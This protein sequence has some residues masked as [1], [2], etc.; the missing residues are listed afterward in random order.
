MA[1]TQ[2]VLIARVLST[3]DDDSYEDEDILLIINRGITEIAG[4]A[5]RQHGN[6]LLAPLPDLFDIDTVTL[7]GDATSVILPATFQ[8]GLIKV[9]DSKGSTLRKYKSF[10]KFSNRYPLLDQAGPPESYAQK[11][12]TIYVQPSPGDDEVLTLHF[13][14]MPVAMDD[15][16][17]EPDGIPE[18]LAERLCFHYACKEIFEDIEQ[19]FEGKKTNALRHEDLYQQA[20]TDLSRHIGPEDGEADNV[21]GQV[22]DYIW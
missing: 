12:R 14:R 15:A 18:Y 1:P 6:E 21:E 11:G 20:L 8:R 13:H 3:I 10:A 7:V 17:D 2:Q 19:G 4:G 16:D 22:S 5:N 9:I